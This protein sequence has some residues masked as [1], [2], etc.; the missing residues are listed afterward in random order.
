M[1]LGTLSP[2]ETFRFLRYTAKG[3]ARPTENRELPGHSAAVFTA[4]DVPR[5]LVACHSTGLKE[6]QK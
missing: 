5:N 2:I 4:C 1:P 3:A 6:E